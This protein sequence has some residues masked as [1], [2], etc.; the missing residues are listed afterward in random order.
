MVALTIPRCCH[1]MDGKECAYRELQ[2][3]EKA[4]PRG[5]EENSK[6][7]KLVNCATEA[8]SLFGR[9]WGHDLA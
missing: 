8:Q 1:N 2:N 9:N 3:R 7:V 6:E 5:G 4:N